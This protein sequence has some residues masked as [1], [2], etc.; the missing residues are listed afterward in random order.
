MREN[1]VERDFERRCFAPY[2]REDQS[3]LNCGK[4]GEGKTIGI[5]TGA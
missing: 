2:L 3:S 1:G 5:R 4:K